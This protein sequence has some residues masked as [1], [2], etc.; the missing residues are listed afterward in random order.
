MVYPG[1]EPIHIVEYIGFL[2]K[3]FEIQGISLQ[4]SVVK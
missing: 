3:M 1:S 4:V 2:S